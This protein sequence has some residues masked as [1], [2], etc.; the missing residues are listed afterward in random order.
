MEAIALAKEI[1]C[2]LEERQVTLEE[3]LTVLDYIKRIMEAKK[4]N[5]RRPVWLP[6]AGWFSLL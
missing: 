1:T 3:A 6:G 5:R 2:L 4:T